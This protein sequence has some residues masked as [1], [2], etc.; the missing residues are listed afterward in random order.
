[1]GILRVWISDIQV[2][3][4]LDTFIIKC[5]PVEMKSII[6]LCA[7]TNNLYCKT[8]KKIMMKYYPLC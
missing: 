5:K 3:Y 6:L 7:L 8:L 2:V 4:N 1:M